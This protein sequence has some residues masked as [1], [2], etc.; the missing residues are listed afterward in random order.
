MSAQ[1]VGAAFS[2]C[3]FA[4]LYSAAPAAPIAEAEA[5]LGAV[6]VVDIHDESL[7]PVAAPAHVR[8]HDWQLRGRKLQSPTM[9][10]MRS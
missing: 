7:R 3:M 10:C 8:K 4:F 2:A 9:R 5:E 1:V 6:G